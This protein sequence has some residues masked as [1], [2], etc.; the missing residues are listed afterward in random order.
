LGNGLALEL[1]ELASPY[2]LSEGFL[3]MARS[4]LRML[5]NYPENVL[6]GVAA[7]A[8][9]T[10]EPILRIVITDRYKRH[11]ARAAKRAPDIRTH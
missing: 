6:A 7:P 2:G 3:H 4:N 5:S 10:S 11:L 8:P 9:G 1:Q